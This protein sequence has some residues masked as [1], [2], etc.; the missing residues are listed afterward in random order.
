MYYWAGSV[1]ACQATFFAWANDALRHEEDAL[2]A[3]VI[4]SM[5][6]GSNAVNAWWSIVFY[7]ASFAPWFTRGMWAMI[8]VSVAS[9]LIPPPFSS[10]WAR[11]FMRCVNFMCMWG[12][13]LCVLMVL[14]LVG[15]HLTDVTGT[16]AI[17]T[18]GIVYMQSRTEKKSIINGGVEEGH[19][20]AADVDAGGGGS[21]N[22]P[23]LVYAGKGVDASI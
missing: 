2:R 9:E 3:I 11:L 12:G 1:Y 14:G 20:S 23:E 6:M 16:V 15:W 19:H 5:N 17:W 18:A 8:G 13:G 4:A 21:V 22:S 10:F 7:G